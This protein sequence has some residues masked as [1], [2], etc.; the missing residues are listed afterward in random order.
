[1]TLVLAMA[2]SLI[3]PVETV[4]AVETGVS[5]VLEEEKASD[6]E[7][8]GKP[9]IKS[10]VSTKA[11]T[12]K[13]TLSQKIS[14]ASGYQVQYAANSTFTGAKTKKFTGSSVTLSGLSKKTWY[15]RVRA[16]KTTDGETVY[17]TWSSA[18]KA[19]VK[20]ASTITYKT[21]EFFDAFIRCHSKS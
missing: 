17:G 11:N 1:M 19:A 14:G 13:V 9:A 6:A 3:T 12:A 15:F 18:K 20:G 16:Y 2:V 4:L 10:A 21:S 5:V 7:A 8:P